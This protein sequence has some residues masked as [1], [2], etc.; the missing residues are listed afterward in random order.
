MGPG[1]VF[2]DSHVKPHGKAFGAL[3]EIMGSNGFL[4]KIPSKAYGARIGFFEEATVSR[5]KG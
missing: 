5:R 2:I 1:W 4:F 3:W